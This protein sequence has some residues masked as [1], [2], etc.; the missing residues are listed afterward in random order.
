MIDFSKE[1]TQEKARHKYKRA[2]KFRETLGSGD[3][4]E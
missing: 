1:Q 4:R 2:L 3:V